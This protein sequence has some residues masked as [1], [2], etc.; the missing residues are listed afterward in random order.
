MEQTLRTKWVASAD[1][2]LNMLLTHSTNSIK[3]NLE[4]YQMSVDSLC[5]V[6][7]HVDKPRNV[8]CQENGLPLMFLD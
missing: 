8:I 4:A 5:Q 2:W 6:G 1:N 3:S 7:T